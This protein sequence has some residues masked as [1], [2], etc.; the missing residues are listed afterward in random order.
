MKDSETFAVESGHGEKVIEWLN[1]EAK[2]PIKNLKLGFMIIP[3][4]HK[5]LDL[6]KCFRGWGIH[7]LLG[8]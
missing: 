5:T 7:N 2:K 4:P 3:L 6:L 8:N 1:V